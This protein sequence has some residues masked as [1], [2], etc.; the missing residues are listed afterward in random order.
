V[1]GLIRVPFEYL[2]VGMTVAKSNLKLYLVLGVDQIQVLMLKDAKSA[3]VITAEE[4]GKSEW[5]TVI[6]GGTRRK[7]GKG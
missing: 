4:Y 6:K 3:C 1:S 7:H 5:F 2:K